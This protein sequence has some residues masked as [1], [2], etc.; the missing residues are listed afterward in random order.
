[1]GVKGLAAIEA[2]LHAAKGT[3]TSLGK[4][5]GITKERVRQI[6]KGLGVTYYTRAEMAA[7]G[8]E[9]RDEERRKRKQARKDRKR[10]RAERI[11]ALLRSCRTTADAA[12]RFGM[13]V[14]MLYSEMSWLR[15]SFPE[16][17]PRLKSGGKKGTKRP[18][19]LARK[20][21]RAQL[22]ANLL[23]AGKSTAA[24]AEKLGLSSSHSLRSE[25]AKLRRL[26]P[27]LLKRRG[28]GNG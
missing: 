11:A 25:M 15:R 8:S 17:L 9:R 16:L 6:A 3:L 21:A 14:S 19:V 10:A 12:K 26:F 28:P 2:E 4:K 20:A 1:L 27:K 13:T 22:I 24:V 18:L 7:R 5:Y 23:Q